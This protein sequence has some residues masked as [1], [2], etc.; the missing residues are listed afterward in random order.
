MLVPA[1]VL[2]AFSPAAAGQVYFEEVTVEMGPQQ[3]DAEL[4]GHT[5]EGGEADN[6]R[7]WID[8]EHGNEDGEVTQNELDAAVQSEKDEINSQLEIFG[9]SFFEPFQINKRES[10][11]QEVTDIRFSDSVLG[12]VGSGETVIRDV[13]ALLT[14]AST[15][16]T[17]VEFS[18]AEDFRRPF[19]MV[20]M[21]WG[22]ATFVPVSPW[23]IDGATISPGGE[24]N[25]FFEDGSFVVPYEESENFSSQDEPLVFD[26]VDTTQEE[27]SDEK[28]DSPAPFVGLLLLVAGCLAVISSKKRPDE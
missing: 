22:V 24:D 25:S 16:K 6:L 27:L 14:F 12:A 26:L 1:L 4:S 8:Q 5:F 17:R 15:E 11:T 23:V 9:N 28:E 18:F 19:S 20:D 3:I 13:D 10:I 2:L 7:A 21:E